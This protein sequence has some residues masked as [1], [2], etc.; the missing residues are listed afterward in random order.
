MDF[1]VQSG[2]PAVNFLGQ[3]DLSD[4]SVTLAALPGDLPELVLAFS[5]AALP[6]VDAVRVVSLEPVVATLVA[7]VETLVGVS[8]EN[9]MAW[10]GPAPLPQSLSEL[11]D[12]H[13]NMAT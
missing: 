1:L 6:L 12:Q 2:E 11:N 9:V 13:G 8:G 4:Q 3:K 10:L 5:A 7:A